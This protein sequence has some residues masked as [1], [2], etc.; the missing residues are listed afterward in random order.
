MSKVSFGRNTSG[1][2]AAINARV[3]DYFRSRSIKRTGNA[4][5]YTKAA[6]LLVGAIVIYGTLLF[7]TFPWYIGLLLC[8]LFGFTLACIG[9]NIMHDACHGGFSASQRVNDLAGLSLNCLGGNAFI[10]KLK[11]N[12][13]H[14]T[15]TN[16][17]GVDDDIAKL[18][19]I[20]QCETQKWNPAHRVQHFYMFL[21]YG[22]SSFLWAFAMD[23]VKYFTGAVYRTPISTFPLKEHVIF[24]VSKLLYIFF[25]I[26]LPIYLL[27]FAPW[28]IGFFTM[29]FAMGL[30][31]AIVFQLAHVVE[32]VHFEHAYDDKRIEEEWAKFQVMTTAN[33][34]MRSKL[35]SWCV[36]GLNFQ[37]E[38]HLFPRVSHVHYPALAPIV[39]QVCKEYGVQYTSY[40]TVAKAVASHYRFMR[41]LGSKA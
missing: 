11:H 13:I 14:H 35:V 19:L 41:M 17:D 9:F 27:G 33:F 20:R 12:I 10:W 36:G 22:L 39:Q 30:T 28:I 6:I 4:A 34:A 15:Y 40:P 18:P 31:L 29:H 8:L 1:F 16:V 21:I 38:H 2:H 25:Y 32:G 26:A 5:L 23:F 37:I 3:E 7:A 24:W